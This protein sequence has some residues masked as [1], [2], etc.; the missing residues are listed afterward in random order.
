MMEDGNHAV[1]PRFKKRDEQ[2]P[3]YLR[4]EFMDDMTPMAVFGKSAMIVGGLLALIVVILC[5]NA[6][7]G[8]NGTESKVGVVIQRGGLT[9]PLDRMRNFERMWPTE[10]MKRIY[11][12][13]EIVI[14]ETHMDDI[15]VIVMLTAIVDELYPGKENAHMVIEDFNIDCVDEKRWTPHQCAV[16]AHLYQIFRAKVS[17]DE[18]VELIRILAAE[19]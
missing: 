16:N 2:M 12:E 11:N 5:I 8:V 15:E 3:D 10:R 13:L 6:I 19:E 17:D 7:M 14:D 9:K 18:I 4:A 1:A